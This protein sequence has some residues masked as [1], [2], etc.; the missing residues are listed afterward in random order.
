MNE[1]CE[2]RGEKHIH[3]GCRCSAKVVD[4]QVDEKFERSIE[5]FQADLDR[6]LQRIDV[7]DREYHEAAILLHQRAIRKLEEPRPE[8][9]Q[10]GA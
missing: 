7:V 4:G 2:N 9:A 5:S 10:A 8:K 6:K 3:Y 1:S